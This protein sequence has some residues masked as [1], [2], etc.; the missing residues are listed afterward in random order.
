M[1]SII[2][3]RLLY[4]KVVDTVKEKI[5]T[6]EFSPNEKL[7]SEIILAE[8]FG[9]SRPTLRQALFTLENE[10]IIRRVHG[11]G[12]FVEKK[13]FIESGIEELTSMTDVIGQSGRVPGT[14]MFLQTKVEPDQET[15]K[16]LNMDENDKIIHV[17]RIRTADEEP[18][19]YC[20]D[21]LPINLFPSEYHFSEESLFK[22]LKNDADI[23]I[24]Y[25][26]SRL[27]SVHFHPEISSKLNCDENTSL[28]LL[29]Q[30]H[31]DTLNRPIL[32]SNNYFKTDKIN[33]TVIRKRKR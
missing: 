5:R 30:V 16:L 6:G 25:A 19:M 18:V 10:N 33:F 20:I 27:E 12:T 28:L 9:I 2:S 32:Y 21:K 11:M 7:P 31:Y 22:D 4:L 13:P 14:S 24:D 15:R 1:G 17:E 23:D 26:V 3:N 29:K 8:M